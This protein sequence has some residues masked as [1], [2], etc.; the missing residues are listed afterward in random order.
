MLLLIFN[1]PYI[2][3]TLTR[4]LSSIFQQKVYIRCGWELSLGLAGEILRYVLRLGLS[5]VCRWTN[6]KDGRIMMKC[7][8]C[9]FL[10]C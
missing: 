7:D 9:G 6:K 4:D 3:Y 5:E 10:G 1:I 2:K 8:R